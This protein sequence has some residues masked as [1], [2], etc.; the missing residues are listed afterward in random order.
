MPGTSTVAVWERELWL[1]RGVHRLR[2]VVEGRGL[3][4]PNRITVKAGQ[5]SLSHTGSGHALGECWPSTATTDGV[6]GIVINATI[7]DATT[8]LS[9]LVHEL[10]HAADDCRDGHGAWF[11]AWARSLGLE[12]DIP[13]TYAG[14]RLQQTLR[15]IA[16]DL[17]SYPGPQYGY[18]LSRSGRLLA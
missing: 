13:S 15:A 8:I 4:L 10:V 14:P 3:P 18:N 1:V 17:G 12:G 11:T 7:T 16:R 2:A 5:T 6:P 9:V